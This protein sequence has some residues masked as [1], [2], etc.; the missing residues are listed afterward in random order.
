MRVAID[1]VG[2]GRSSLAKLR[3]LPVDI[4]KIDRAFVR[5]IDRSRRDRAFVEAIVRLAGTLDLVTVA[6]GIETEGQLTTL[7]SIGCDLGQGY[8]LARPMLPAALAARLETPPPTPAGDA[9]F[10]RA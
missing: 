5:D 3:E 6:E 1:D 2:T 9:A 8:H 7:R 4:L 10:I